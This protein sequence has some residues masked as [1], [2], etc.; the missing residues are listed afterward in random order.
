MA[1]TEHTS[2]VHRLRD[3]MRTRSVD[4]GAWERIWHGAGAASGIFEDM[5]IEQLRAVVTDVERIPSMR[6]A[7]TKR[8][9]I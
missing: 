3:L 1:N 7:T 4:L 2:L 8:K 5:S 6:P 9:A